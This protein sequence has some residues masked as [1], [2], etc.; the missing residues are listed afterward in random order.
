MRLAAFAFLSTIIL[1]QTVALASDVISLQTAAQTKAECLS[2]IKATLKAGDLLFEPT[3]N[4]DVDHDSAA[5]NSFIKLQAARIARS[6]SLT[7]N[8]T[9]QNVTALN[10]TQVGNLGDYSFNISGTVSS[11]DQDAAY[12]FKVFLTYS[13]SKPTPISHITLTE[14]WIVDGRCQF[15]FSSVS[16]SQYHF[17]DKTI[18]A[19]QSTYHSDARAGSLQK[20]SGQ[21]TLANGQIFSETAYGKPENNL[22]SVLTADLVKIY[23]S[24]FPK[25]AENS[26]AV[27]YSGAPTHPL[28]KTEYAF[29]KNQTHFDALLNKDTVFKMLEVTQLENSHATLKTTV[30]TS[31]ESRFSFVATAG[32][33]IESWA[34]NERY[35]SESGVDG[36][37]AWGERKIKNTP[38]NPEAGQNELEIFTN[39]D[40]DYTNLAAYFELLHMQPVAPNAHGW[41]FKYLLSP[42]EYG[43]AET[44]EALSISARPTD[45]RDLAETKFAQIRTP[46]VQAFAKRLIENNPSANRLS[47]ARQILILVNQLL[48][49]DKEAYKYSNIY[50]LNTTDILKRKAGVC[51]HYATL[52]ASL[53]RAVG[54]PTRLVFGYRL[55]N[56]NVIMHAWN[57]IEIRPGIWRPIEPQRNDLKFSSAWYL[58]LQSGRWFEE[59]GDQSKYSELISNYVKFSMSGM[60]ISTQ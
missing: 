58:P 9:N 30:G 12:L 27:H 55:A 26:N 53:A 35:W 22:L 59:G 25:P 2:K 34:V 49:T 52:F 8:T 38:T 4:A 1:T 29:L 32:V 28:A 42:I 60:F 57:E 11:P 24:F 17:V 15:I 18:Y 6:Y 44:E 14:N 31:T 20:E 10:V 21:A 16:R 7:K 3:Q 46:E 37:S 43:A 19:T 54:I 33:G 41:K 45:A 5:I 50:Q 40:L 23:W 39:Q 36:T 47:M 48:R 51:Q 56:N 13:Q